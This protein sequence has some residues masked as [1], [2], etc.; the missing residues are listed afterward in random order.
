M[1]IEIDERDIE[2]AKPSELPV[3][4]TL[5]TR[6]LSAIKVRVG[7]P[8]KPDPDTDTKPVT[9]EPNRNLDAVR[10][11]RIDRADRRFRRKSWVHDGFFE[12]IRQ[13]NPP[14]ASCSFASV[15]PSTYLRLGE[16]ARMAGRFSPLK[17]AERLGEH[18]IVRT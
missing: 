8:T 9:M 15:K 18:F 3:L 16:P 2:T 1:K 4:L 12:G 7:L 10:K 11:A 14:S 5:L 17:P 13:S 6:L